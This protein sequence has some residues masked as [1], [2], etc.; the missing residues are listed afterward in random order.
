MFGRACA[1]FRPLLAR[2]FSTRLPAPDLKTEVALGLSGAYCASARWWARITRDENPRELC[3]DPATWWSALCRL[4]RRRRTICRKPR[5]MRAA[6]RDPG[7]QK[8]STCSRWGIGALAALEALTSARPDKGHPSDP[9][10][11]WEE[12]W[13]TMQQWLISPRRAD[14][15]SL[16]VRRESNC[17]CPGQRWTGTRTDSRFPLRHST[18]ARP[19]LQPGD[20]RDAQ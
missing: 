8:W 10:E 9:I 14:K 12:S 1:P 19:C 16:I 18:T 7:C 13:A 4:C 3:R 6:S 20:S 17:A 2:W 15:T 11:A 5:R